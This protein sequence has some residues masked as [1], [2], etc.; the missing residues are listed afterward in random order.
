MNDHVILSVSYGRK[1]DSTLA[2]YSDPIRGE[3]AKPHTVVKERGGHGVPLWFL[4]GRNR[5]KE[6]KYPP[7]S[8]GITP[9]GKQLAVIGE[10]GAAKY[11]EG[12]RG[13]LDS[14]IFLT[15]FP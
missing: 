11:Q 13:P 3:K 15:P 8:E 7:M 10:S 6:I 12:G 9:F 1:N 4:D 5:V 2:V 14:I